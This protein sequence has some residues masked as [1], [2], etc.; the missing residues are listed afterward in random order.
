MM[1]NW[2][3]GTQAI[4]LLSLLA[5][6]FV[7]AGGWK[8]LN[9]FLQLTVGLILLWVAIRYLEVESLYQLAGW[10]FQVAVVTAILGIIMIPRKK[11]T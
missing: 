2:Q 6:I 11:I 3:V 7:K 8:K 9:F 5:A 1:N 10:G 4:L